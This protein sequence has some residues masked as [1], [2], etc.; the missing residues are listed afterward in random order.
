MPSN[1]FNGYHT[2][3]INGQ[4]EPTSKDVIAVASEIGLPINQT[5]EIIEQ[6][7]DVCQKNKMAKFNLK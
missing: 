2:T 1:G 3:T 5:K 6:V 4:G 7:T